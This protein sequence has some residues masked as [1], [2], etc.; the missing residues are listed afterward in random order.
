MAGWL[1]SYLDQ[2]HTS[3]VERLGRGKNSALPAAAHT[4]HRRVT[5]RRVA[6]FRFISLH[7][8]SLLDRSA[9]PAINWPR[10]HPCCLI[11]ELH[12]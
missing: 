8:V 3:V 10:P 11:E 9:Q 12:E 7:F 1:P 6:R 4:R 2:R 5:S